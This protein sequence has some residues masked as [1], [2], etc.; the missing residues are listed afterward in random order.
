MNE[1]SFKHPVRQFHRSFIVEWR[2]CQK[3]AFKRGSLK[4][5]KSFVF[6]AHISAGTK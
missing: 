3:L 1:L 6:S 2:E 5:H 4:W